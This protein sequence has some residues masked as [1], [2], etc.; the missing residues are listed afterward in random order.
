MQ[1]KDPY[2][3]PVVHVY[4]RMSAV[5]DEGSSDEELRIDDSDSEGD[6]R[7]GLPRQMPS[8]RMQ[9]EEPRTAE[10]IN[11]IASRGMTIEEEVKLQPTAL[12]THDGHDHHTRGTEFELIQEAY[13]TN[14][15]EKLTL[16]E[17]CN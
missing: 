4:T 10:A 9:A 7:D 6:D 12:A 15:E 13:E 5:P 16:I 3:Q 2:S 1:R 11:L 14:K 17:R 8:Q